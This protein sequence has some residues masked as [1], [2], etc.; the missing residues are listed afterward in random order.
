MVPCPVCNGINHSSEEPHGDQPHEDL[1]R[2]M[3]IRLM[4]MLD[5]GFDRFEQLA[6]YRWTS[7]PLASLCRHSR[8]GQVGIYGGVTKDTTWFS[9]TGSEPR[10]FVFFLEERVGLRWPSVEIHLLI[11]PISR[12]PLA[13][14]RRSHD[15]DAVN[16]LP[17]SSIHSAKIEN[18]RMIH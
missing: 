18:Q 10:F 3:L 9:K 14:L 5:R 2:G 6:L 7:S 8:F 1:A 12:G 17:I 4:H 11:I 16:N 15:P 13:I